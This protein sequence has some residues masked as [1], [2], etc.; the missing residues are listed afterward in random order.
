MDA[1]FSLDYCDSLYMVFK[2]ERSSY[3]NNYKTNVDRSLELR[4]K[5]DF[6]FQF[7]EV[8]SMSIRLKY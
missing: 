5:E 8:G 4:L 1:S 6:M 2:K 3:L 7:K